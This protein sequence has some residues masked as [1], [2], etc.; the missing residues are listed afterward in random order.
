MR[1]DLKLSTMRQRM[2]SAE[3]DLAAA[4]ARIA[5]LGVEVSELYRSNETMSDLLRATAN[6][7]KGDPGPNML[8]SWHDLPVWAGK[9][10]AVVMTYLAATAPGAD[11]KDRENF[12]LAVRDWRDM[13]GRDLF[14]TAIAFAELDKGP[15]QNEA[16]T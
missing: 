9:A 11:H 1:D 12:V 3:R 6:G 4:N 15:G 2:E 5:E 13:Y 10:R 7:L 8:H 16:R 14:E